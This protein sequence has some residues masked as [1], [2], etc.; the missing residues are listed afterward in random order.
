MVVLVPVT[1][2]TSTRSAQITLRSP[3]IEM[4]SMV[5]TDTH[6]AFHYSLELRGTKGTNKLSHGTRTGF[7]F[8]KNLDSNNNQKG[9]IY[10]HV[11]RR[12]QHACRIF[13]KFNESL[14]AT[15]LC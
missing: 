3:G 12:Y 2:L 13:H 9:A 6:R 11:D 4:F 8:Q 10:S 1:V 15:N 14:R 5:S 7:I